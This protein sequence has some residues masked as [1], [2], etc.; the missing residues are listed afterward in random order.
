MCIIQQ[1]IWKLTENSQL[2][3]WLERF[4]KASD[5]PPPSPPVAD[6][7]ISYYTT[8]AVLKMGSTEANNH[9]E[10][11]SLRQKMW[12]KIEKRHH[13]VHKVFFLSNPVTDELPEN[14]KT[15]IYLEGTVEYALF[16]GKS[17]TIEWA[18]RMQFNGEQMGNDKIELYKVY[19]DSTS[20]DLW[21]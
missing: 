6:P 12:S 19:I 9:A 18:G 13:V 16:D 7:Y 4:Y 21:L 1:K 17:T 8:S 2:N 14:K 15:N 3:S 11:G 5:T 10:I 20:R